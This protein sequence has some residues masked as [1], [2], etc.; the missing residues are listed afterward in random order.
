MRHGACAGQSTWGAHTPVH[1][2][3]CPQEPRG[4]GHGPVYACSSRPHGKALLLAELQRVGHMFS[5]SFKTR[6][7]GPTTTL[8]HFGDRRASAAPICAQVRVSPSS[9]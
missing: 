8:S 6:L 3:A 2:Y 7:R 4:K 5:R 9:G 1:A